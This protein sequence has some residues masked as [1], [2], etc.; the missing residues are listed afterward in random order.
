MTV[1]RSAPAVIAADGWNQPPADGRPIV[2]LSLAATPVERWVIEQ[3]ASGVRARTELFK[4]ALK[5]AGTAGCSR[6]PSTSPGG[7][8]RS[9]L[10]STTSCGASRV[11]AGWDPAHHPRRELGG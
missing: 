4:T 2:L 9:G 7:G 11:L 10:S 1:T 8:R 6:A 3:F 5:L